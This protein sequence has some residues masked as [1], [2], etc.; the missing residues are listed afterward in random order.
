MRVVFDACT[1][2][3]WVLPDEEPASLEAIANAPL[4][5]PWLFWA[6]LRNIPIASERR[7]RIPR[8]QP[9]SISAPSPAS[10]W[11]WT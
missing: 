3:S 10:A 7:G 9:R 4:E 2:A 5:A 6:E 1:A 8:G 11:R